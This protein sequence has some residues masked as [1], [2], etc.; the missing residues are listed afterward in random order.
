MIIFSERVN[1]KITV[2]RFFIMEIWFWH[3]IFYATGDSY[4]ILVSVHCS[5]HL[6]GRMAPDV[7]EASMPGLHG[8]WFDE[9]INLLLRGRLICYITIWRICHVMQR[10]DCK[11]SLLIQNKRPSCMFHMKLSDRR[12]QLLVFRSSWCRMRFDFGRIFY[13]LND[14]RMLVVNIRFILWLLSG[15]WAG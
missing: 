9:I 5:N 13:V 3:C 15:R 11:F 12:Q 8:L 6:F 2:K 1:V 7:Y 10:A 14:S 4:T